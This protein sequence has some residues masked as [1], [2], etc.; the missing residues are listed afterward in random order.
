MIAGDW[1]NMCQAV[2]RSPLLP[3]Q[4]TNSVSTATG[5][6]GSGSRFKR[7][8]LS[9]LS[10]YGEKKTG[11]LVR[12]LRQFNFDAVHAALVASIPCKQKASDTQG[13]MWGWPAMKHTLSHIPIR[14]Q[15]AGR[16]VIQVSQSTGQLQDRINC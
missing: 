1:A 5:G 16:V 15:E 12:Q 8:L 13:T 14:Q 11:S 4:D 2:W 9:Y 6:I 10:A 3:L 7:D